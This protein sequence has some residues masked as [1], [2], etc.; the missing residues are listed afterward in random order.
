MDRRGH[1]PV[2]EP[3]GGG[4]AEGATSSL[5]VVC[6]A[7][8]TLGPMGARTSSSRFAR[9]T[10]RSWALAPGRRAPR[11]ADGRARSG[12]GPSCGQVLGELLVGLWTQ[13]PGR[14]PLELIVAGL[15]AQA[16]ASLRRS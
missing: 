9:R 8:P 11:S 5:A 2:L 10:V 15:H 3:G 1:L 7:S 12:G 14:L 4:A 16:A 13:Q 6:W